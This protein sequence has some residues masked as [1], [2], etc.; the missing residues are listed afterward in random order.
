MVESHAPAKRPDGRECVPVVGGRND[1]RVHILTFHDP[2]R[3][4]GGE[5][6]GSAL[7]ELVRVRRQAFGVGLA[8]GGHA[9][10]RGLGEA[11][12]VLTA[13]AAEAD[14]GEAQDEGFRDCET[15]LP[16]GGAM[17]PLTQMT[18][19]NPLLRMVGPA[20]SVRSV[21]SQIRKEPHHA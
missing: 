10:A 15:S 13:L 20:G 17:R 4:G 19:R 6:R 5:H 11:F 3:I 14:D 21:W 9:H 8:Q 2:P 16:A 7:L 1:H 18:P 12:D